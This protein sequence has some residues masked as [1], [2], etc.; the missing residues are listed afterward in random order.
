M[1]ID[2]LRPLFPDGEDRPPRLNNESAQC[3]TLSEL[4]NSYSVSGQPRR[5]MP[6]YE[7]QI[8]I[9]QK[10]NDERNVATGLEN[11]ADD[12]LK[13]GAL[14]VAEASLHRSIVLSRATDD[15]FS[16]AIEHRYLG[17][18]LAYRGAH[19]KSKAELA[20][21]LTQFEE[22]ARVQSL[23]VAW[24][25]RTLGDLLWLRQAACSSTRGSGAQ[26]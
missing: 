20:T 16:E 21:A 2:L 19:A 26:R 15:K 5:A 3:W 11:V 24:A 14:R 17:R 8:A 10:Q 7:L 9:R 22:Q 12:R 1:T 25:F 23:G 4:A 13:I 18:L 6:L